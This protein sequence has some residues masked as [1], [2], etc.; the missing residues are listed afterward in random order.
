MSGSEYFNPH[1]R[2]NLPP[3]DQGRPVGYHLFDRG[4]PAGKAGHAGRAGQHERRDLSSK[5]LDRSAL[6]GPDADPE[7]DLRRI[8]IRRAAQCAMRGIRAYEL[9]EDLLELQAELL[10]PSSQNPI[11]GAGLLV[12]LRPGIHQRSHRLET[13]KICDGDLQQRSSSRSP[14]SAHPHPV[15]TCL[16]QLD[17]GEISDSIWG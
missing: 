15:A 13:I 4:P 8:G 10:Q 2:L 1:M 17:A 12:G 11:G 5:A 9:G 16:L 7:L 6:R 3:I 14:Y